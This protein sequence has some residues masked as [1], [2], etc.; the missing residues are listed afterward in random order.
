[1]GCAKLHTTK[2]RVDKRI[3]ISIM[4]EDEKYDALLDT[5]ATDTCIRRDIAVKH[6]TKITPAEGVI[7]LAVRIMLR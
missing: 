7:I 4:F 3:V 2:E 1:M 5:G 6:N